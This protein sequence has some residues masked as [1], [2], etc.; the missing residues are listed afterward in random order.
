MPRL[1]ICVTTYNRAQWIVPSLQT[2]LNQSYTDFDLTV[3]DNASTDNTEE[4]VRSIR[5]PRLRYVRNP[6]NCGLILNQNRA[7]EL[8]TGELIAI[9]HDDDFYHPDIVRR[10]IEVLDANPRV[11]VVC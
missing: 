11:G 9:Y 1:S 10:S 6:V 5:D 3:V 2:I 8:A 7:I 4:L